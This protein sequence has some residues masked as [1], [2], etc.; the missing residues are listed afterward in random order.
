MED[1]LKAVTLELC[2]E[3]QKKKKKNRDMFRQKADLKGGKEQS[4]D[5]SFVDQA[6]EYELYF[7]CFGELLKDLRERFWHNQIC[8]S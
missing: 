5:E 7:G 3:G 6:K 8:S 2:S 1:R 4:A